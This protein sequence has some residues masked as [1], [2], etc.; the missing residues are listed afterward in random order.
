MVVMERVAGTPMSEFKHNSLPS[1]VFNDIKAAIEV[2]HAQ[3]L[4]F[5]DLRA[6]NVMVLGKDSIHA[7]LVDFDWTGKHDQDVYPYCMGAD[8]EDLVS[9]GLH[10]SVR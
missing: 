9:N 4:V 7:M 3:D 5:G 1:I 8:I 2:L 6:E 10:L